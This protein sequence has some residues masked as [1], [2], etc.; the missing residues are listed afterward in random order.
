MNTTTERKEIDILEYWRIVLKRKWILLTFS[1]LL[2]TFS[3][4]FS[5]TATPMY[6]ATASIMIE[7]PS[8]GVFNL[9][10]V[11]GGGYQYDYMGTYFNTQLRLLQ[12]RSLA[13]R[14]A[15]K[16]NL[17][18]RPELQAKR[19]PRPNLLSYVRRVVSLSWLIPRKKAPAEG[20]EGAG[21]APASRQLPNVNAA[22]AG[23][24]MGGLGIQPVEQTRLVYVSQSSP[25]PVLAADIVNN[26]VEEFIDYS[27]ETRYEAT[28]QASEFLSDQIARLRDELAAR[29]RELQRY[30]EEKKLLFLDDKESSVVSKYSDVNSAYTAAQIDRINKEALWRELKDLRIDSLPPSINNPIV[31]SLKTSYMQA[32]SEYDE[33]S[34]IWGPDYPGMIQLK[35][36]LDGARTTLEAELGKA[37][38]AAESDYRAALKTE[39]SLGNLLETQRTD[40]VKMNNNAILYNNLRVDVENKRILLNTLVAKQNET[41]VS[42][43]LGG[44][45]SSSIRIVDKALVPGGPYSPNTRRSLMMALLLGLI[46]GLGLIFLVE[47]LDNSVKGP[48]DVEKLVGLPSLGVIP[49]LSPDATKKRY[50]SGKYGYSYRSDYRKSYGD[51][52]SGESDQPPPEKRQIELINHLYPKFSISEDYRTV[53]T[54]ILFSHADTAP[55]VISFTSSMPQ[56][57]KTST[58]ANLAVAFA[59]LESRILVV[60]GDLRKPRMHKVFNSRNTIGLAGYLTGKVGLEEIVQKTSIERIWL[61]PSG[62]HPPNPSELLNSKR[63]KELI[64]IVRDKFDYVLI[65]APPALAVIDP[66]IISSLS[67]VTV[68]II[69]AGKTTRKALVRAVGE[70][71]KSKAD[72]VGVVFNEVKLG[73]EGKGAHYYHYYQ[74]EYMTDEGEGGAGGG[75]GREAARPAREAREGREARGGA[76]LNGR[77]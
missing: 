76:S 33:K 19:A 63:M 61:V 45:R 17:A 55:K 48:E 10:D 23:Y 14:V 12:S 36:R 2:V 11:L 34:K 73:A 22:Y 27:V 4:I 50:S 71:R 67:D 58:V 57:G 74:Y 69:R 32:K 13:E 66:V 46:G 28:Q 7:E 18:S 9:Q 52:S 25:H 20:E 37:V 77:R 26:L 1:A 59:Q 42:A 24:V 21:G 47:F 43:R 5:Y 49:F 53:R 60:D 75:G 35:T 72:I 70:V 31:Q 40:V 68:F 41:L 15:K 6:R 38:D 3:G 62:P 16:M 8:T 65:D 51:G 39:T 64:R 54:S 30:G 29:E 56:E 44:L